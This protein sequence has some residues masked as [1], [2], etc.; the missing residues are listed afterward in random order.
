MS[1]ILAD[2]VRKCKKPC[3][4]AAELHFYCPG[5]YFACFHF[6]LQSETLNSSVCAKKKAPTQKVMAEHLICGG[7]T[8]VPEDGITGELLQDAR[9]NFLRLHQNKYPRFSH[10][11][12]KCKLGDGLTG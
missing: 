4:C 9:F 7:T 1:Q 3:S 5:F 11:L 10:K 8:Y 12:C 2:L 6:Y